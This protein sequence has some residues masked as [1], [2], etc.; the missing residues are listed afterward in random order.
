MRTLFSFLLAIL[1]VG[2]SFAADGPIRYQVQGENFEGYFLQPSP[3]APLLLLVHDWDGLTDYE[4]K[5][6]KMLSELGYAV[7]AV[8]LFGVGIRPTSIEERKQRTAALYSDRARM[9]ALLFGGLEAAKAHGGNSTN[10]VAM[11]YCFGG[12]AVLEFAR[13]GVDLKG[14]VSF[15]GGLE[16]PEGQDYKT[17]KGKI[18]ILHGSAD[19]SVT[20]AHF[21]A[22]ANT[23]EEQKVQHEMITYSGAPHAFTVFG[24][25]RYREDADTK[26]W[27]RFTEF[28]DQTLR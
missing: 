13:S 20:M 12:A 2:S 6:A 11:G 21:A 17:S 9:R 3:Q 7:F 22:L 23:L 19:T 18:L 27:K 15:H 4:I 26:S 28:L 14:F 5:R 10:S 25:D 8:D 16:T 1:F 24:S